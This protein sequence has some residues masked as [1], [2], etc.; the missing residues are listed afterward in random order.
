M[1]DRSLA[2]SEEAIAAAYARLI[3]AIPRGDNPRPLT[4]L[5]A[6]NKFF[7]EHGQHCLQLREADLCGQWR[8]AERAS[9]E[10]LAGP[11][12]LSPHLSLPPR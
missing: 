3:A 11:G 6:L 8:W 9:R 5:A 4:S 1:R 7:R 12:S 2:V 10:I